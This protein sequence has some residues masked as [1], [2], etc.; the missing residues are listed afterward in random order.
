[1]AVAIG[2]YCFLSTG[3][4]L[5]PPAKLYRGVYS[6]FPLKIGDNVFIGPGCVI[7]AASIGSNVW[8]GEGA[9][10]GRMAIVK[11]NVRILEG[12]VVPPG[13][14]IP[15]GCVVG[16]RPATILDDVPIGWEGVDGRELWRSIG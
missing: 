5:R 11:E 8:I 12:A 7:E 4:V 13:M 2:K 14:V 3:A 15:S 10:L 16:G 6:H 9:V 1:M